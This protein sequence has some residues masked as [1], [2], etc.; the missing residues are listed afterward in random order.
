[1]VE[2]TYQRTNGKEGER[3]ICTSFFSPLPSFID[4][5]I[6]SSRE[7][8][9]A[10]ETRTR[11]VPRGDESTMPS[12][13]AFLAS[14]SR[15]VTS[16]PPSLAITWTESTANAPNDRETAIVI[17]ERKFYERLELVIFRLRYFGIAFTIHLQFIC[18]YVRKRDNWDSKK[19][20]RFESISLGRVCLTN[21]RKI[22]CSRYLKSIRSRGC[23]INRGTFA[24]V[25]GGRQASCTYSP[26]AD[27]ASP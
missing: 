10:Y 13:L 22:Y 9:A 21:A 18:R 3:A 25:A 14:S 7:A 2:P 15:V 26:G 19:R 24:S 23:A 4:R 8:P 20:R 6:L 5:W 12:F 17:G 1:M 11:R 16:I 27:N